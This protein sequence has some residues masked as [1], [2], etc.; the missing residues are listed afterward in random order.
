MHP[1]NNLGLYGH[2]GLGHCPQPSLKSQVSARIHPGKE[3]VAA[4][5]M[6]GSSEERMASPEEGAR[7]LAVIQVCVERLSGVGGV[8]CGLAIH[9][10]QSDSGAHE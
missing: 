8:R 2:Q 4:V 1:R 6:V 9:L 3:T 7:D 10:I 5:T